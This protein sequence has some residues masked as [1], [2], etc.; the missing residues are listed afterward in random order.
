MVAI[1][2]ASSIKI[3]FNENEPLDKLL[4]ETGIN[5]APDEGQEVLI[6]VAPDAVQVSSPDVVMMLHFNARFMVTDTVYGPT[7][8]DGVTVTVPD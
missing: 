7:P 5:P 4:V 2:I 8:P 3:T 6:L 1:R